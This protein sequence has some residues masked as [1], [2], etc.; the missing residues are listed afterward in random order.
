MDLVGGS[1]F[2]CTSSV[3]EGKCAFRSTRASYRTLG[4]FKCML[5]ISQCQGF[6]YNMGSN[7]VLLK[8]DVAGKLAFSPGMTFFV[9][10]KYSSKL[11]LEIK[12]EE[13]A[14]EIKKVGELIIALWVTQEGFMP[15][16]YPS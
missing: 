1:D 8:S 11:D 13:C 14:A 16:G 4:K 3:V 6:V 2:E 10:N 12:Y 15:G 5:Y 9:K 7:L